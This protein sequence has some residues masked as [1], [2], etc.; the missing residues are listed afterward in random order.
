[1]E[2]NFRDTLAEKAS[3]T[4]RFKILAQEQHTAFLFGKRLAESRI[5]A[6]EAERKDY[7]NLKRDNCDGSDVEVINEI[8]TVPAAEKLK[9]TA[10]VTDYMDGR[11]EMW[12]SAP[13]VSS[14]D[15]VGRKGGPLNA[16]RRE[17]GN[18]LPLYGK[19][20]MSHTQLQHYHLLVCLEQ[21]VARC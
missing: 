10:V 9:T 14:V 7:R 13:I 2:G 3:K 21:L 8:S 5:N 16:N 17:T 15:E 6:V 20:T 11:K 12:E 18:A 19:S 4:A 1:M